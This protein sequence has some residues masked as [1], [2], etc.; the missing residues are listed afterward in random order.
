MS[1][2]RR[3]IEPIQAIYRASL[4]LRTRLR[5]WAVN[6]CNSSH[7]S[8][9]VV[10]DSYNWSAEAKELVTDLDCRMDPDVN[11]KDD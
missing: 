2:A 3:S 9:T 4:R 7:P 5:V 10:E 8:G 1:V 6:L 11:D